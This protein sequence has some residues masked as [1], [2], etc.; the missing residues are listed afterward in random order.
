M[1]NFHLSLTALYS[2]GGEKNVGFLLF[3]L[4][5]HVFSPLFSGVFKILSVIE[6]LCYSVRSQ[7]NLFLRIQFS[8][9]LPRRKEKQNL[10][11]SYKLY[12]SS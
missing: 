7:N 3:E 4:V 8:H 12:T 2:S 11:F 1:Y 9:R 6:I 10:L 5:L